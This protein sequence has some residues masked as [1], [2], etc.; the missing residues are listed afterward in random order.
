[1]KRLIALFWAMALL[2]SGCGLGTSEETATFMMSNGDG[3]KTLYSLHNVEGKKYTGFLYTGYT[4]I[5]D[6]GYIVKNAS[7]QVGFINNEGKTEIKLGS[8]ATLSGKH[9][10]FIGTKKK[11]TTLAIN[12]TSLALEEEKSESLKVTGNTT[13]VTY[14]SS[15]TAVASVSKK[16]KVTAV[17]KG[18]AV[19]TATADDQ[20]LNCKVTVTPLQPK[21]NKTAL[22]LYVGKKATLKVSDKGKRKVS[23]ATSDQKIAT[24]KKGEITAKGTGT[25]TISVKVGADT[26]TCKVTVKKKV[27]QLSQ[28]EVTLLTE[29]K[30]TLKVQNNKSK[31]K[32][33]WSTSD[34]KIATVEKGK[35]TAKSAG[36]CTITA[37]VGKTKLTCKV[38]VE[39]RVYSFNQKEASLVVG[40]TTTLSIKNEQ[41]KQKVSWSTSDKK[42]ATVKKGKI[43]AKK[44]GTCTIT[45]KIADTKLTCKVTVKKAVMT[46]SETTLAMNTGDKKTLSVANKG[47]KKVSWSTSNSTIVSVSKKGK[48]TAKNTGTAEILAKIGSTELSCTVKVKAKA[49]SLSE[50]K[51]TLVKGKT[52]TLKLLNAGK[53]SIEWSSDDTNVATVSAKGKVKTIASGSAVITAKIGVKNYT[54]HLTVTRDASKVIATK[55]VATSTAGVDVLNASGKVLYKASEKTGIKNTDLPVIVSD[56]TYKVLY[57][58]KTA[59][60]KGKEE[61]YY[62]SA[63]KNASVVVVG[64]KA[65]IN[66]YMPYYSTEKY[67]SIDTQGHYDVMASDN[68]QAILYDEEN[69]SVG[70]INFDKALATLIDMKITSADVDSQGNPLLYNKNNLSIISKTGKAIALNAYYKDSSH[71]IIRNE[72]NIYGPHTITNGSKTTTIKDV[73]I[74]PEARLMRGS[75]FPVYVRHKGFMYY[76]MN[77]KQAIDTV[78]L[79]ALAFD[80]NERAI[81]QLKNGTYALIDTSG[82]KIL[83]GQYAKIE[84]ID[85]SYYAVYNSKGQFG[86]YNKDGDEVLKMGYTKYPENAVVTYDGKKYL[87]LNKNGRSYVYNMDD[88]MKNIFSVEGDIVLHEEGYFTSGQSYYT[89]SGKKMK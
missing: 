87:T 23:Y 47:K 78:Y 28:S 41:K 51:A 58:E 50:T 67:L 48:V 1:M 69:Q 88:N 17:G 29:G 85:S 42:I 5:K 8:Y 16:G 38:K 89:M 65:H 83:K 9:A 82:E 34:K 66:V 33:K 30:T 20:T 31:K 86:V 53:E 63:S 79:N 27:L 24:V 35:V 76:D 72:K 39:Q 57:D 68:L 74:Y 7:S 64:F 32:T 26:L 61:V 36:T 59:L 2:L 71:Y 46:L 22:T 77:G 75:L 60:Y 62:V 6:A 4:A 73:Q 49:I 44:A 18:T 84:Y 40:K 12:K 13:K 52:M 37:T 70:Y 19:I 54:C 14:A 80:K 43:T 11:T 55:A 81:I 3:I 10:L 25:C 15:N 21:L 45:A 56:G